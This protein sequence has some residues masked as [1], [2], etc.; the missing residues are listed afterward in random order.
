[1][2]FFTRFD[3]PEG[4]KIDQTG[5][6]SKTR[7]SEADACDI[8]KIM[9]RFNRTGRLPMM[10]SV[11]PQY[12][13]ARVVDYQTAQ[14]LIKDAKKQFLTL[15]AKVRKAFGNDPQAF[16][17]ALGDNSPENAKRLLELG[18]LV[19]AKETPEEM[20]QRIADNTNPVEKTATE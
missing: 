4:S 19:K 17:S 2:K 6:K 9:E 1:M 11:P 7:Q 5:Q 15:P 10:Q 16:L 13:D 20:L 14:N 18:V 8:N 3:A 12:G